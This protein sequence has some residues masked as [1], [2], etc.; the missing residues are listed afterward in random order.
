MIRRPPRSPRTDTL[1]PYTTL[2]RSSPLPG[3]YIVA[4]PIGNLGDISA[5]AAAVLARADLIAA[6]D[7]RVTAPLLSHLGLRLKMTPYHA[8][9]DERPRA[10]PVSRLVDQVVVL[11][12]PAVTPLFSDP[13]HILLPL[14]PPSAALRCGIVCVF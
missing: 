8:H 12:S 10:D 6:E 9:S 5:R 2:F 1:F 14:P 7:T 11:L 4:T 3:L 13:R